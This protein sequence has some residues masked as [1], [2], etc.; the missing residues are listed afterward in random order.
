MWGA[1]WWVWRE[2]SVRSSYR[3]APLLGIVRGG[4]DDLPPNRELELLGANFTVM[5]VIEDDVAANT[6]KDGDEFE[7]KI[8]T[9]RQRLAPVLPNG[10]LP[11]E[12]TAWLSYDFRDERRRKLEIL[13]LVRQD[14][15]KIAAIPGRDPFGGKSFCKVAVRHGL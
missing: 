12:P 2:Q 13:G 6:N 4:S 8:G 11:L 9:S 7:P 3:L 10:C 5:P 15:I 1:G 14:P